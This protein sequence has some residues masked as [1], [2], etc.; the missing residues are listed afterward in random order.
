[1]IS[2]IE[3]EN[4]VAG[5]GIF[6]IVVGKHHHEKNLCPI[7]LFKVDK[8]LE[9]SFHCTIQPLSLAVRLRIEGDGESPLDAEEIA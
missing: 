2:T 1:M 8:G 9:V 4:C 5:A 3:L 6:G 7:I